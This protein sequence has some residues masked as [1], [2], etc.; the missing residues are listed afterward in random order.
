MKLTEIPTDDL[1]QIVRDN[2][3][4]VGVDAEST[5]AFRAELLRRELRQLEERIRSVRRERRRPSA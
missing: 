4:C 1:R 3:R 5:L 2:E